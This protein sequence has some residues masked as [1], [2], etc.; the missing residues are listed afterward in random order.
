MPDIKK[1]GLMTFPLYSGFRQRWL[2]NVN[3]ELKK[4]DRYKQYSDNV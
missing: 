1:W 3:K 2:K 4:R